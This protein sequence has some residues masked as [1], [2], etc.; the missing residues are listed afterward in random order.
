MSLTFYGKL[1]V[2]LGL[3]PGVAIESA[4]QANEDYGDGITTVT[5]AP[6]QADINGGFYSLYIY[7]QIS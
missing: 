7:T 4:D 5:Y 6:H 1:A 3:S 2:I